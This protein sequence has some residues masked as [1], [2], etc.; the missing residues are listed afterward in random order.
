MLDAMSTPG[1]LLIVDDNVAVRT[2]LQAYLSR[3]GGWS[4]VLQANDAASAVELAVMHHP[5]A[6]VLD[7]AMPGLTG[8]D[9]LPELRLACPSARIVM[10]TSE[11]DGRLQTAAVEAGADAVVQK[12]QPLDELAGLLDAAAA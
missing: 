10:H 5:A 11:A 9:V 6:I 7:N 8:L 1:P 4:T 12:G 3:H 2:M